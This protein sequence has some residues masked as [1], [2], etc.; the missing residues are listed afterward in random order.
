MKY[1]IVISLVIFNFS[2][3]F[4]DSWT[5]F[6]DEKTE[7]IGFKDSKQ[8]IVIKPKFIFT[9]AK[10]F[11][12]II[13]VIEEISKKKYVSYYLT[14]DGKKVG[15]GNHYFW[16]NSPDC[17]SD[18]SIRFKDKKGVG[19]FDKKGDVL[20]PSK[21]SDA[22]P[23]RNGLAIVLRGATK[24]CYNGKLYSAKNRCE[25]WRWRGGKS[26]LI[27]KNN[28][29]LIKDF[30]YVTDLNW[31]SLTVSKKKKNDKTRDFFK[32]V[33]GKYYSFINYRKEFSSWFIDSFL[34]AGTKSIDSKCMK[35]IYYWSKKKSKWINE[36]SDIFFNRDKEIIKKRLDLLKANP[37]KY[38]ISQDF[39]NH[40]I[41]S[42]EEYHKYY[43]LCGG[44]IEWKYPVFSVMLSKK[45][46]KGIIT[47]DPKNNLD[48][49]RT[50]KGYRL[51]SIGIK[52]ML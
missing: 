3:S 2:I 30:K 36:R 33:N 7:L 45:D 21:Y 27:D 49:L 20:I 52:G 50:D 26:Y 15:L 6:R 38:S 39:L 40:Y 32:G 35:K 19:F 28:Q 41:Y 24:Y 29:I 22:T 31:L 14:K 42:S 11:L 44:V 37:H 1:F 18:E 4:S 51:I 12:N 48:F 46:K 25:H 8:N 17:E 16:D 5:S 23:F 47:L 13:A 43:S 10:K 9:P 34:T